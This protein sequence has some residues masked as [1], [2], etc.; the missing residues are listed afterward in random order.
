MKFFLIL[1][2]IFF[3]EKNVK[4]VRELANYMSKFYLHYNTINLRKI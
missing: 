3:K 1:R 2:R 4:Y